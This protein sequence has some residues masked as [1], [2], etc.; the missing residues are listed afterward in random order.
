MSSVRKI[1]KEKQRIRQQ[2]Q[3]KNDSHRKKKERKDVD[4]R[5]GAQDFED[6]DYE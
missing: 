3:R 4:V 5:Q 2:D 1:T 6:C